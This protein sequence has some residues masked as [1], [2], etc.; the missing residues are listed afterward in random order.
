MKRTY[1]FA[2]KMDGD[3]TILCCLVEAQDDDTDE[4]ILY[5]GE[6]EL[7]RLFKVY[8]R[9][10]RCEAIPDDEWVLGN[11]TYYCTNNMRVISAKEANE[12]KAARN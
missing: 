1:V 5:A 6:N 12:P 3:E 8:M 10:V 9:E 11:F 7:Q 2:G 4:A